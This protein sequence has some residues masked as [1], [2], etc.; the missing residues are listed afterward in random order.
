MIHDVLCDEVDDIRRYAADGRT[1]SN[2]GSV[3]Y[4]FKRM[5]TLAYVIVRLRMVRPMDVD[6]GDHASCNDHKRE[7]LLAGTVAY[8]VISSAHS[9]QS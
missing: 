4:H 8:N 1:E 9:Q 7:Q 3:I 6:P 5:L 2:I